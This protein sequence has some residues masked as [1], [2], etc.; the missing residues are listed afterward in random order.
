MKNM[1]R[2]KRADKLEHEKV[3]RLAM[4][5]FEFVK[6]ATETI[7]FTAAWHAS[8]L[9]LKC[10]SQIC[11][12][13]APYIV[14]LIA[15]LVYSISLYLIQNSLQRKT[16]KHRS[17]SRI[18]HAQWQK[19]RSM[20]QS[21]TSI[22]SRGETITRINQQVGGVGS[23]SKGEGKAVWIGYSAVDGDV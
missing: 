22:L 18:R 10:K 17:P 2:L 15:Q 13:A 19:A 5:G 9:Q 12:D 21:S 14:L 16:R 23:K 1:R 8:F 20:D 6:S 7:A 4:I 11:R 3:T